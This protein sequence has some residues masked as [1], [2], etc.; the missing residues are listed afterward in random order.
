[1]SVCFIQPHGYYEVQYW[2]FI[3]YTKPQIE[4]TLKRESFNIISKKS[5]LE[6]PSELV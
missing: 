5:N 3:A 2:G 6:L 4:H 1:M